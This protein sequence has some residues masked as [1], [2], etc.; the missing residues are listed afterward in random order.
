M[1]KEFFEAVPGE[2]SPVAESIANGVRA[3]QQAQAAH[4]GSKI[5]VCETLLGMALKGSAKQT[6]V[7]CVRSE[8]AQVVAGRIPR[9]RIQPRILQMAEA[10][11]N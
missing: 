11:L 6:T 3:Y 9:D 10:L 2:G 4:L 5:L 1:A 7:D 8:H